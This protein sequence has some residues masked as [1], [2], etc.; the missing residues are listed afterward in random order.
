MTDGSGQP[1]GILLDVAMNVC[2][3]CYAR[4]VYVVV[5]VVVCV[6]FV[7]WGRFVA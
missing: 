3:A 1:L 7:L 6:L 4:V 5:F 2:V